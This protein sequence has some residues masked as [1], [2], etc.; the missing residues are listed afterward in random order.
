[1]I[2]TDEEKRML[3]GAYGEGVRKSINLLVKWGELF[4][5]ERMVKADGVHSSTNFPIDAMREMS[6]GSTKAKAFCTTHAVFDPKYYREK[7]G[8]VVKK[9]VGG[10]AS[11][12]EGKFQE[13]M[14]LLRQLGF[15]PTFTCSPYTIGILPLPGNVL[16]MT[17]SSG[18]VI[19][20]TFFGARASRESVSTSFAAAITGLTPE[21][22]LLKRENRYAQVLATLDRDLNPVNFTDADYGALGYYLGGV[23]GDRNVAITGLPRDLT[24]ENGRLLVSPLPVSGACVMCHI[25]GIT[26]ES[27]TLE[28]AL[29]PNI[30]AE[31]VRVGRAEIMKT[32]EKL[33]DS[34]SSS[35][36]MAVIGC[37]HVTIKELGHLA[38]LLE[39]KRVNQNV[40]L[41]I[42]VAELVH[43]LGEKC[44]YTR[45]IEA[46]GGIFVNSCVSSR[47]PFM[48]LEEG[49][50]QVAVTNSARGAHYMQRM[51]SGRTK[52]LYAD[53]RNCV[54]ASI[55]GRL[56]V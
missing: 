15:L 42:G 22:G 46:A 48:F 3:D 6:E 35:I 13:R 29:G 23:L 41:V 24:F 4:D 43:D 25:V 39:G 40:R 50:P 45:T 8:V 14:E 19:S 34:R 27:S 9:M 31:A 18:Q 28:K 20:N 12:D 10:S 11:T 26:P 47:N 55:T 2:L 33:S 44:G 30:R 54:E 51:S 7:L 38:L 53:M 37:P 1:M 32:Y 21:M 16:C 36:D 49:A 17:G 56:E 5:A 52:T